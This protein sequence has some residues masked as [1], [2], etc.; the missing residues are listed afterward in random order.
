VTFKSSVSLYFIGLFFNNLIMGTV[1]GDSVRL[2][3]LYSDTRKGSSGFA[4][5]FLD[6]L[7]SLLALSFFAVVGASYLLLHYNAQDRSIN[8]VLAFM[9]VF[10]AI[11]CGIL[12]VVLIP[13]LQDFMVKLSVWLPLP[14]KELVSKTMQETFVDLGRTEDRTMLYQAASLALIV[15]LMRIVSQMFCAAALGIFSFQTMHFFLIIVPFIALL[16]IIP[17]PFGVRETIGGTLF[18]I[19]GI[20]AQ[21]A[22]IM[23]FLATIVGVAGSMVGGIMFLQKKKSLSLQPANPESAL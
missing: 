17:L 5:T 22:V 14:V 1:I 10:L 6:R 8:W 12:L 11:F 23:Q 4:A 7:A 2:A 20:D 16:M 9:G 3:Y 19:A 18:S 13:K 15:Q 21:A